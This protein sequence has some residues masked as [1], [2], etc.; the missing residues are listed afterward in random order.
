MS[1]DCSKALQFLARCLIPLGLIG[2]ATD[3][4]NVSYDNGQGKTLHAY[5][6]KPPDYMNDPTKKYPGAVILHAWNGMSE[7]PVYFADLLARQGYVVIAPDL[8]RNIATSE[9]N[10]PW[11]IATTLSTPQHR[12]D[13]DVDAAISYLTGSVQNVDSTRVFSGPGFCFGGSQ[14]LNLSIRRAMAGTITLYGANIDGLQDPNNNDLWGELGIR[15]TQVLGIYGAD[16]GAPTPDEARGFESALNTRNIGNTVTIY[17]GVGH[18]FV[19]PKNHRAGQSQAVE[20]WNQVVSVMNGV[21]SSGAG[22]SRRELDRPA[23]HNN[24][25]RTNRPSWA[26]LWDHTMDMFQGK[27]HFSHF[28]GIWHHQKNEQGDHH[29]SAHKLRTRVSPRESKHAHA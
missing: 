18:A 4:T 28:T 10:I 13:Q 11:N 3:F 5:L 21:V 22:L 1:L 9:I 8:F 26:W 12:M 19:S 24:L 14:A 17:D 23:H 7:E 27:G 20:A 2:Q 6:A 29:P 15:E 25:Q 16:D